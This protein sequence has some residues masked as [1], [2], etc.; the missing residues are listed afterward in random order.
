LP[1]ETGQLIWE[2]LTDAAPDMR[3]RGT[4]PQSLS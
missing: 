1:D 3:G 2:A 4:S